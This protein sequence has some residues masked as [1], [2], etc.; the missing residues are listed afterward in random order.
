MAYCSPIPNLTMIHCSNS[1]ITYKEIMWQI[2]GFCASYLSNSNVWATS[3]EFPITTFQ[4]KTAKTTLRILIFVDTVS[5]YLHVLKN[6]NRLTP[7]I[8]L[9]LA[10]I[11]KHMNWK[12]SHLSL[13]CTFPINF[14]S[15]MYSI[16]IWSIMQEQLAN[17]WGEFGEH[18][19][20]SVG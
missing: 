20:G 16:H 10:M 13:R 8:F 5:Q 6:R 17:N 9:I 11:V 4:I 12:K 19:G 14:T 18:L 15:K 2:T 7:K 3:F 1:G